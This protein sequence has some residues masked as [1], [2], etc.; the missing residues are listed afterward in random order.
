MFLLQVDFAL[1]QT[2]KAHYIALTKKM[3][4]INFPAIN[5][6]DLYKI[7]YVMKWKIF[8]TI[9]FGISKFLIT[10]TLECIFS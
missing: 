4:S 9:D 8:F 10:P 7:K 6:V 1:R 2:R 5:I 3:I